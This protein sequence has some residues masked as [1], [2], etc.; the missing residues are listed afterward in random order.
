[1]ASK[2]QSFAGV[3]FNDVERAMQ[4]VQVNT[5]AKQTFALASLGQ[6]LTE[7]VALYRGVRL[8][9]GALSSLPIPDHWRDHLQHFTVKMDAVSDIV[10]SPDFKAGKDL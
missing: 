6:L 4:S 3:R 7:A 2:P 9:V 5:D 8:F 10:S 1:M